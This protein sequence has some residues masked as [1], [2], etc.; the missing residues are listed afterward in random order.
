MHI[1]KSFA[2]AV[3]M[4]A[5]AVCTAGTGEAAQW[6]GGTIRV[7]G[8]GVAPAGTSGTQAEALARRAAISDAYRQLAEQVNGVNVDAS[9]TVENLMLANMTVRTHVSALIKG[10][11]IREEKAQRDGS[12]TV[13]LELPVYGSGSLASTVFAP[14][15]IPEPWTPPAAVYVPYQ[16]QNY[17]TTGY[18]TYDR[19]QMQN[20]AANRVTAPTPLR[21][22][23]PAAVENPLRPT[24]PAVTTPAAP[25]EPTP[26]RPTHP[27]PQT[28][29]MPDTSAPTV[30]IPVPP[31]PTVQPPAAPAPAVQTPIAPTTPPAEIVPTGQAV[32]GY[33]G[34][35]IDCTGLGLRP[36]MSPVIKAENGRPIYGYK[37]LD[38]D[39]V[40]A[41][42]MASYARSDADATRA[43]TNPLRL[44]AVSIDGGANPVLSANDANRLL[45]ENNASGFLDATNVVFL[46]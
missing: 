24:Q 5:L 21:P 27:T 15:K 44:R 46:R 32:G 14:N 43:G 45:L 33:T 34:V 29:T 4:L 11:E 36:A 9:T 37:N 7:V 3:L 28:S 8:L 6:D 23:T 1:V 22:S 31:A 38:S 13:T 17:D 16:P 10:V 35:I 42:G 20:S 18:G 2:L 39:K 26:L 30:Q 41:S 40:V 12:Y 25:S 19:A